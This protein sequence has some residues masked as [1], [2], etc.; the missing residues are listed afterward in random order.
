MQK[1]VS[2]F[3]MYVRIIHLLQAK[4]MLS[5]LAHQDSDTPQLSL[6]CLALINKLTCYK[7]ANLSSLLFEVPVKQH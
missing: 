6:P 3:A 1:P 7:F 4:V 5:Y 2:C